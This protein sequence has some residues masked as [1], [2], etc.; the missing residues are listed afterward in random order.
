MRLGTGACTDRADR[1][2]SHRLLHADRVAGVAMAG[3]VPQPRVTDNLAQLPYVRLSSTSAA[4][5]DKQKSPAP[6]PSPVPT[7]EQDP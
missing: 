7:Q 6:A 5:R 4:L 1:S 3:R 2:A